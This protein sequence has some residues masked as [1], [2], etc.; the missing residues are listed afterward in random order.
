MLSSRFSQRQSPGD[1]YCHQWRHLVQD[2][3]EVLPRSFQPSTR[4]GPAPSSP[5]TWIAQQAQPP[6]DPGSHARPTTRRLATPQARGAGTR[7]LMR[8][9][10]PRG[11]R[12]PRVGSPCAPL[13]PYLAGPQWPRR[14]RGKR[15]TPSARPPWLG[16]GGVGPEEHSWLENAGGGS[17]GGAGKEEERQEEE[18][19]RHC[20]TRP[21]PATW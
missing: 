3:K 1:S 8:T 12:A 9:T 20:R 19:C 14:K 18:P 6:R 7:S 15:G 2:C 5:A 17:W 11:R 21:E 10:G 4:R 16:A 13:P